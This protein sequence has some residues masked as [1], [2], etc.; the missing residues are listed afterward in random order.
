MSMNIGVI[1]TAACVDKPPAPSFLCDDPAY[2]LANPDICPP[3]PLFIIKPGVSIVCELGSIKF[4]AFTVLNGLETDVTS[5]TTFTSSDGNV[6]KV[7]PATG[8]ATGVAA[9]EAIITATYGTYTAQAELTVLAGTNCCDQISVAF[10]VLVDNS[11][12]MSQAF[13]PGYTSKLAYAKAAAEALIDSINDTKDTVGLIRFTK[14]SATVLSGL[15]S[16]N[17][18]VSALVPGILQTQEDTT[19]YDALQTAVATLD[20]SNADRKVLVVISDGEDTSDSYEDE[21]PLVVSS[22]FRAAG[23]IV[24][25]IG[26]RS[27]SGGYSLLSGLATGGFFVNAYPSTQSYSSTADA[28]IDYAIGLKGYICGGNCIEDGDENDYRGTLNYNSLINW[29]LIDVDTIVGD[30]ED[31]L[32]PDNPAQSGYVDLLG[33]GFFDFL[34]G[35]GLYVDLI[36]GS[37]ETGA[38]NPMLVS[39]EKFA[40]T[41][42]NEYRIAIKFSRKQIQV[43]FGQPSCMIR[44]VGETSGIIQSFD[45]VALEYNYGILDAAWTFPAPLSENVRVTIWQNNTTGAPMSTTGQSGLLLLEVDFK[46]LT[47]LDTLLF[48]D[49]DTENPTY[50]GPKCGQGTVY[51]ELYTNSYGGGVDENTIYVTSA[52]GS[53][54]DSDW[55]GEYTKTNPALWT[56]TVG[57]C[58]LVLNGSNWELFGSLE[59]PDGTVLT[60]DANF[61]TGSW[62]SGGSMV[63]GE[64]PIYFESVYGYAYGYYC[65]GD[66]CLDTPP[67]AQ[68][69]DPAPL[70]NLELGATGGSYSSTQTACAPP[71]PPGMV[72]LGQPLNAASFST[73]EEYETAIQL[74]SAKSISFWEVRFNRDWSTVGEAPP[75]YLHLEGSSDGVTWVDLNSYSSLTGD[76]EFPADLTLRYALPEPSTAYKYYKAVL[77]PGASSS[78]GTDKV[79]T[80]KVYPEPT[81][82]VCATATAT[83]ATAALAIAS[84]LK[85]ATD[86]AIAKQVCIPVYTANE[87]VIDGSGNTGS[88][89]AQSLNSPE[90]A[91]DVAQAAANA[92]LP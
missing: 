3:E 68:L 14:E 24:I 88:A 32:F 38:A 62:N 72:N 1:K 69:Q 57:A 89:S 6:V 8:D 10:M 5:Q 45:A 35:N 59:L 9:G 29:D 2:A 53:P 46:D 42:G 76:P 55:D 74:G 28:V 19:F 73:V 78:T 39:K 18:T 65:Y 49:F 67:P 58:T 25:C 87:A 17:A 48:D 54:Y 13:G 31:S 77:G 56:Q 92:Q 16:Q 33:N 50:I 34:P 90:E 60:T 26:V 27:H 80:L 41:A 86:A 47:A 12:S 4:R 82:P 21:N 64:L 52:A 37:G 43:G 71:C 63:Y 22:S 66:G 61:S 81:S 91:Q 51:S 36:S 85:A 44:I 84:A 20:A 83:G 15:T 11:K 23:G 75:V 40:V 30:L 7:A 79:M 70:P